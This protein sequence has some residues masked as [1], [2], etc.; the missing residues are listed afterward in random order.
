M[1]KIKSTLTGL[2]LLLSV[3][4]GALSPSLLYAEDPGD[5]YWGSSKLPAAVSSYTSPSLSPDGKYLAVASQDSMGVVH[6]LDAKNGVEVWSYK[7]DSEIIGTPSWSPSGSAAFYLLEEHVAD[8]D[9]NKELIEGV[10]W[11]SRDLYTEAHR[12]AIENH[13]FDDGII[14]VASRTKLYAIAYIEMSKQ[15]NSIDYEELVDAPYVI[16][17][18][19][20]AKLIGS[21]RRDYLSF[22]SPAQ[23]NE[24][25][26]IGTEEGELIK[27]NIFGI[28]DYDRIKVSDGMIL[29]SPSISKR[30]PNIA[31]VTASDD[32]LYAIDSSQSDNP[33]KWKFKLNGAATPANS[34][35][36]DERDDKDIV[37]VTAGDYLHAI[38]AS[39]GVELWNY[40]ASKSIQTAPVVGKQ[41]IYFGSS[42][43]K[44]YAV[45]QTG[46]LGWTYE[47]RGV[48]NSTPALGVDANGIEVAYFGSNDNKL[49]AV[50]TNLGDFLW[51]YKTRGDVRSSPILANVNGTNRVHFLSKD[52]RIY[53]VKSS[54][55]SLADTAWPRAGGDNLSSGSSPLFQ[56]E[57]F[58]YEEATTDPLPPLSDE[59][60][61]APVGRVAT[62]TPP[63]RSD[64]PYTYREGEL[65][66]FA[67]QVDFPSSEEKLRTFWRG[68]SASFEVSDGIEMDHREYRV[69]KGE[70]YGDLYSGTLYRYAN[71]HGAYV[72]SYGTDDYLEVGDK[73][74]YASTTYNRYWLG[75][76]SM[77]FIE[78]YDYYLD[79]TLQLPD[80][81]SDIDSAQID[82][83]FTFDVENDIYGD[84]HGYQLAQSTFTFSVTVE[85]T[86]NAAPVA[87][88]TPLSSYTMPE[89]GTLE[90]DGSLSHD[91][92]GAIEQYQWSVESANGS[93]DIGRLRGADT[94]KLYWTAPEI[95]NAAT[96]ETYLLTLEVT[97]DGYDN[98]PESSLTGVRTGSTTI[99][100]TV[101]DNPAPVADAGSDVTVESGEIVRLHGSDSYDPVNDGI[102]NGIASV[103][104]TASGA[105]VDIVDS[106]ELEAWFVAPDVSS[107]ITMEVSLIVADSYGQQGS[108]SL[109]VTVLPAPE[110][111]L[112]VSAGADQSVPV[113]TSASLLGSV[114]GISSGLVYSWR[115]TPDSVR[116][117]GGL[118]IAKADTPSAHVIIPDDLAAGS[119]LEFEFLAR[120]PDGSYGI[121]TT[122]VS[123]TDAGHRAWNALSGKDVKSALAASIDGSA[124]YVVTFDGWLYAV[125]SEN[126]AKLWSYNTNSRVDQNNV[127][128]SPA[129]GIVYVGDSSGYLHAVYPS[130]GRAKWVTQ[131]SSWEVTAIAVGNGG[132][133]YYGDRSSQVYAI[134][135]VNGGNKWSSSSTGKVT[136]LSLYK[137]ETLYVSTDRHGNN[138]GRLDALDA[139]N[140][141]HI[142]VTT[143]GG[144]GNTSPAAI[145]A[146]G[147][148]YMGSGH[149]IFAIN[150]SD[151]SV[152]W[153]NG[154]SGVY[155]NSPVLGQD[156]DVLYVAAGYG[157]LFAID[158]SNGQIL[159]QYRTTGNYSAPV[160]GYDG[161]IYVID[162]NPQRT[163]S[164]VHAV[165]SDGSGAWAE[166]YS[167]A[168]RSPGAVLL[169]DGTLVFAMES[170]QG[171]QALHTSSQGLA[172]TSWPSFGSSNVS[173]SLLYMPIALA[174]SDASIS[175]G[176][177]TELDGSGSYHPASA[178]R[179]IVDYY[180][181]EVSNFGGIDI[182][183]N[184]SALASFTAPSGLS[185]D[186]TLTFRLTVTDSVGHSSSDTVEIK[187]RA[188]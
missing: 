104:W 80:I 63:H 15:L 49:Y 59:I 114:S 121:D 169:D 72:E 99:E 115:E 82:L 60:Y 139:S 187:V 47:T 176:D 16:W 130:N 150:P 168:S 41:T 12:W 123:I 55:D 122:K 37:Y 174:G 53:S 6:V 120:G 172:A 9:L 62:I 34:P 40:Q 57:D 25:V 163:V 181:E 179:S 185:S 138:Y 88:I 173:D 125:N 61:K 38:R 105:D 92:E 31:Y 188:N 87:E 36:L 133:V 100:I 24:A 126:G 4:G 110:E 101:L 182:L 56:E 18:A 27:F 116:V 95:A 50:S 113:A 32:Y 166:P 143:H 183:D 147:T 127:A 21:N 154:I 58:D 30:N 84:G 19:D 102:S 42:D 94:D 135:A 180:W 93:A 29:S 98:N 96:A 132:I 74:Y 111:N 134:H 97:D 26:W 81:D 65:I 23:T 89:G 155:R 140:G 3:A 136:G 128:V 171:I 151:G 167:G 129:D 14:F 33:I 78:N 142:W 175:A 35:A 184:T 79:G 157:D 75:Q 152:K 2:L 144:N 90:L 137:N 109:V 39:D 13:F 46:R 161:M 11:F 22:S 69:Y 170:L 119:E 67:L 70:T 76:F 107:T 186:V 8:G 85:N 158:S 83:E 7:L 149:A 64:N 159:W 160:V 45:R 108:D 17:S 5:I 91:R 44:L 112:D 28:V 103:A 68:D 54:S 118:A 162:E 156:G 66:S 10:D 178:T 86:D 77:S 71:L 106:N 20:F 153:R 48:V 1:K 141:S 117:S 148:V 131:N 145:G 124:I 43:R 51:S 146:D 165:N 177:T 52:T 164:T 73:M